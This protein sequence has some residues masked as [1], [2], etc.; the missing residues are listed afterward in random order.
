MSGAE[1]MYELAVDLA[2]VSAQ[3]VVPMRAVFAEAGEILADEWAENAR[4]TSGV[5]GKHYPNSIDSELNFSAGGIEVEVG[6]NSAK[7]QGVMGRGFEFGSKNQRPH[8]DGL[9]AT[10]RL[11]PVVETMVVVAV[12]RLIP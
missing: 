2:A 6:P 10:E 3:M 9:R 5:H 12:D 8:L 11:E 4:A 7:P 1:E